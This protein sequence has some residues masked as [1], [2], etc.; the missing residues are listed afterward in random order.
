[1]VQVEAVMIAQETLAEPQE[2][3]DRVSVEETGRFMQET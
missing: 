3:Q 2:L 1:V